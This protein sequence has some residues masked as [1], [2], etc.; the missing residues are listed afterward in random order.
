MKLSMQNEPESQIVM[1]AGLNKKYEETL[2][3]LK[4]LAF[5]NREIEQGQYRL[6]CE[7]FAKLDKEDV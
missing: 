3:L 6:A 7:V 4:I 5:G 1:D 2:V